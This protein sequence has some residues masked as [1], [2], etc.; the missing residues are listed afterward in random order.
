[1]GW[2]NPIDP[3]YT[4]WNRLIQLLARSMSM[5]CVLLWYCESDILRHYDYQTSTAV[6]P[7]KGLLAQWNQY[8][9]LQNYRNRNKSTKEYVLIKSHNMYWSGYWKNTD[10]YWVKLQE[11]FALTKMYDVCGDNDMY[12][13]EYSL[14]NK[15]F[16]NQNH[17]LLTDGW[18]ISYIF[19]IL[20]IFTDF[21][22][23]N[24][25]FH[26]HDTRNANDLN[27]SFARLDIRKFS[28]RINGPNSWNALPYVVKQSS[29]ISTFK[30]RLRKHIMSFKCCAENSQI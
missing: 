14:T 26:R 28:V 7:F 15:Y 25:E 6:T 8:C 12:N 10:D 9:T 18:R 19:S 22:V 20:G 29:S 3:S 30:Y 23:P 5:S 13:A 21:C 1:M 24:H 17:C 16:Q 4:Q 27:V 11:I 2:V